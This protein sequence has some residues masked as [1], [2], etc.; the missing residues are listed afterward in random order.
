[1][2]KK[3]EELHGNFIIVTINKVSNNFAFIYRK[4]SF[5]NV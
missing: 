1:M 4:Y 3:L 2:L 5:S